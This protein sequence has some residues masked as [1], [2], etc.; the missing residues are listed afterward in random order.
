M[1]GR[2]ADGLHV[3]YAGLDS[4]AT[5]I[6]NE[7]KALEADLEELKQLVK[8]S[9]QYWEGVS[10][11]EFHHKLQRWDTQA[12]HIHEAITKIGHAVHEAHGHYQ[13]GDK[14]AASYFE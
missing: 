5:T 11:E 9:H 7:G 6:G 4:A 13:G 8:K 2:N 10:A 14:K 12:R 1:S 3:V